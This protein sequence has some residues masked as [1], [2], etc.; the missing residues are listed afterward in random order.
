LVL[1][2]PP[3]YA[4]NYLDT[5]VTRFFFHVQ[6]GHQ[7]VDLQGTELEDV[8]VARTEAV[9]FAGQLLIDRPEDLWT[10]DEW[11]MRVTDAADL[12][13]FQLVVLATDGAAGR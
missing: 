9:K 7:Y 1:I 11:T 2:A 5:P 4:G 12:T 8:S 10:S 6:D 3:D 13:L